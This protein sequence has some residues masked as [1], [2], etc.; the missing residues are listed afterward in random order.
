MEIGTLLEYTDRAQLRAWLEEHDASEKEC[1]VTMHK[2]TAVRTDCMR[3]VEVVEE[4]LCF[5]WID[6]TMK[7]LPDGRLAQRISPRRK[8]SHWT[9]RN[10]MRCKELAAKGLMTAAGRKAYTVNAGVR[11][12]E[13]RKTK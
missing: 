1:W 12:K 5:G 9:E 6:S 7:R 8:N 4:A 2:S 13:D 3:Y 10:R 11:E